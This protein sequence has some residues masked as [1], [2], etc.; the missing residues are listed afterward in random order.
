MELHQTLIDIGAV[1]ILGLLSVVAWFVKTGI[2][3]VKRSIAA[4]VATNSRVAT[5]ITEIKVLVCA[6]HDMCNETH[7]RG[8]GRGRRV[9]DALLEVANVDVGIGEK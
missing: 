1:I 5:Q 9:S 4:Q 2:E 3:E 6:L 8:N 7:G